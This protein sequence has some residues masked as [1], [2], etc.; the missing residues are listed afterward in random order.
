[1]RDVNGVT[2]HTHFGDV[3]SP[4][5]KYE[6]TPFGKLKSH[7]LLYVARRTYRSSHRYVAVG[8]GVDNVVT[9]IS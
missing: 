9:P 5:R 3:K 4:F 6:T 2:C 8:R 7:R 1:M